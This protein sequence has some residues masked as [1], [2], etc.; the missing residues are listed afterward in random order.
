MGSAAATAIDALTD[1][2][3][4]SKADRVAYLQG[5]SD[6]DLIRLWAALRCSLTQ[7]GADTKRLY[8]AVLAEYRR[9]IDG[10]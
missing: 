1:A 4:A 7:G 5:L 3:E 8:D 2:L 9:R 10:S 6:L